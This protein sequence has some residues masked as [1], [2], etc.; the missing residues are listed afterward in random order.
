MESSL[1]E[2]LSHLETTKEVHGHRPVTLRAERRSEEEEPPR[3][4]REGA[5]RTL[6]S[7]PDKGMFGLARTVTPAPL[8]TEILSE[9]AL[10]QHLANFLA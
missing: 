3:R 10:A 6:F 4:W 5:R 9:N 8:S 1:R 2:T 7:V